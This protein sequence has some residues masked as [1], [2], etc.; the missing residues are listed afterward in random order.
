MG[1]ISDEDIRR[2][3]FRLWEE[4]GRSLWSH[5][6]DNWLRAKEKL[7]RQGSEQRIFGDALSGGEAEGSPTPLGPSKG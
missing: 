2:E 7:R 4:D 5:G 6:Y 3:A 1:E